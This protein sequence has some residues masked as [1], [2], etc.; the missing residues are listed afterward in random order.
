MGDDSRVVG[1]KGVS[2]VSRIFLEMEKKTTDSHLFPGSPGRLFFEWF[3]NRKDYCFCRD[4]QS[5][6]QGLFFLW[7][8]TSRVL[9]VGG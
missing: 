6:I 7:S 3:W 8:F 9:L 2:I 5:T 1:S 4:L